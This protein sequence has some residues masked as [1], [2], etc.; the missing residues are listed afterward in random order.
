MDG[1]GPL[2]AAVLAGVLGLAGVVMSARTQRRVQTEADLRTRELEEYRRQLDQADHTREL[3]DRY[4]EP[5]VR[6]AYDLQSRLWNILRQNMLGA[7]GSD[8]N[9]PAWTYARESTAWLFGQYFGW[10]EIIRREVQYLRLPDYDERRRL[11][12]AL[13][14]VTHVCSSDRPTLGAAFQVFRAQQRA[15]G[16][17]MIVDGHDARGRQRTDCMGFAAF[18]DA[19]ANPAHSVSSWFGPLIRSVDAVQPSSRGDRLTE[20]QHA[21]IDLVDLVDSE[22]TRFPNH[23][24]RA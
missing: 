21:L 20:L 6:A 12:E 7:Y 18:T 5:L 9:S 23:R 1:V 10:V 3:V 24:D 13:D 14:T 8:R 4:Q 11:T 2:L 15:L 16:E 17:L 22:G 19:L